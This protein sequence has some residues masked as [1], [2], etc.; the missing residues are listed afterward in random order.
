MNVCVRHPCSEQSAPACAPSLTITHP[1]C[2][3]VLTNTAPVCTRRRPPCRSGGGPPSE[4]RPNYPPCARRVSRAGHVFTRARVSWYARAAAARPN[5]ISLLIYWP[6]ADEPPRASADGG[7]RGRGAGS[8]A[9]L[10]V[11]RSQDRP[12]RPPLAADCSTAELTYIQR[13]GVP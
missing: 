5:M 9:G 13:R 2:T 6:D 12:R 1:A 10:Y 8:A 7:Q 3:P 4:A 11:C